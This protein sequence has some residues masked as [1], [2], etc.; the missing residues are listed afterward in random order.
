MSI[1]SHNN[2]ETTYRKKREQ[3]HRLSHN[4][5]TNPLMNFSKFSIFS[6]FTS[7]HH[8][9][10]ST[11][12]PSSGSDKHVAASID[13]VVCRIIYVCTT[14]AGAYSYINKVMEGSETEK[15][16]VKIVKYGMVH[17]TL[18]WSCVRK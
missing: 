17:L 2:T 9:I 16:C 11:P 13:I 14:T 3:A 4:Y 15:F 12:E 10:L 18:N 6:E 8:H 7:T 1:S 5:N